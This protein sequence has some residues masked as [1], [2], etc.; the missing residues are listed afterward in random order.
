MYR[1]KSAEMAD[2][3]VKVGIIVVREY[4]NYG[5]NNLMPFIERLRELGCSEEHFV[6]KRVTKLLDTVIMLQYFAM[7][8][9][10]D[11][12]IILAPEERVMATPALMDAITRLELQWNMYI[13]MGGAERADDMQAMYTTFLEME[14]S[15]PEQNIDMSIS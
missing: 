7:Y 12:V 15:A 10:V 13:T 8:T 2:K 1:V 3:Q 4:E 5:D 11:S 9:D 6:L 14:Q